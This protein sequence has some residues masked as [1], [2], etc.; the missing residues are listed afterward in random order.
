[1]KKALN[2][3]KELAEVSPNK[4]KAYYILMMLKLIRNAMLSPVALGYVGK[5][6]ENGIHLC[7][8]AK[9]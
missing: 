9:A 4:R 7:Y 2:F 6:K 8:Q 1:L 5:L 3:S